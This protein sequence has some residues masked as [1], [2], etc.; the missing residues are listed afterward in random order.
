MRLTRLVGAAE[1]LIGLRQLIVCRAVALRVVGCDRGLEVRQRRSG[2]A[3]LEQGSAQR[4]AHDDGVGLTGGSGLQI[5]QRRLDLLRL[6]Q[7]IAV[8]ERQIRPGRPGG[9]GQPRQ[10][11][12][13][14]VEVPG[15]RRAR[16]PVLPRSPRSPGLSASAAFNSG[17]RLGGPALIAL[18]RGEDDVHFGRRRQRLE[19]RKRLGGQRVVRAR[20]PVE[21]RRVGTTVGSPQ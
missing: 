4:R 16:R 19:R 8:E 21:R 10:Q 11:G 9:S 13:R 14:F 20:G 7:G 17:N 1:A 12:Q 2:V 15:L 3:S 5:G 18:D 6:Q